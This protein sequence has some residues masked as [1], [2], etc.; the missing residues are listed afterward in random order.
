MDSL[1]SSGD[2]S[3]IMGQI[4]I[5]Q[6]LMVFD[7]SFYQYHPPSMLFPIPLFLFL[8][9]FFLINMVGVVNVNAAAPLSLGRDVLSMD[10]P[11]E[12]MKENEG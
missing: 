12:K 5:L 7:H 6:I 10:W 3:I 1:A 11:R 8:V 2:V 9:F 4:Q